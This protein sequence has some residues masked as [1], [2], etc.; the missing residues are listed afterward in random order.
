MTL[1]QLG[2]SEE[3]WNQIPAAGRVAIMFLLK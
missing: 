2:I 1:D 3:D